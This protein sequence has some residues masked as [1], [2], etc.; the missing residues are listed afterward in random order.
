MK[1]V[2]KTNEKGVTLIALVVTIIILLILASV[3]INSI[4]GDNGIIKKTQEAK[5]MTAISSLKEEI[6]IYSIEKEFDGENLLLETLLAEG[7]VGRTI[8]IDEDGNYYI[9]YYIKSGAFSSMQGLGEHKS[10]TSKDIFLIDDNLN[11]KYI[12]NDKK[13]Y[14][15]DIEKKIIED[16]TVI[17]FA[18][19]EFAEYIKKISGAPSADK[20]QFQWMKN[21]KSLTIDD[22]TITSIEDLIFFPNLTS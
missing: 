19:S 17:R 11:V 14:G 16:E 12:G 21:L 9:S 2:R 5:I 7:K 1:S 18:N 8:D 20:I 22:K 15:D 3:S 4:L 6:G 13:I 10:G